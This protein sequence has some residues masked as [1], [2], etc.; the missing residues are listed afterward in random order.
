[1]NERTQA[2]H[3][4]LGSLTENARGVITAGGNAAGEKFAEA[5]KRLED[6]LESSKEIFG[7]AKDMAAE[8]IKVTDKAVREN[9]YQAIGISVGVGALLGFLAA[10]RFCRNG[11]SFAIVGPPLGAKIENGPISSN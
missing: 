10:R 1:M 8:G 7:L 5:R 6:A 4:D 2:E 9:P 11:T 3:N